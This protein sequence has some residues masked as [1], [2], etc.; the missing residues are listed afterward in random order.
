M[1][2]S[3]RDMDDETPFLFSFKT[4]ETL[5]GLVAATLTSPLMLRLFKETTS[6]APCQ[7]IFP[8]TNV[9]ILI[10]SFLVIF[11]AIIGTT[12]FVTKERRHLGPLGDITHVGHLS[13]LLPGV[14]LLLIS[15]DTIG[16]AL[17]GIIILL[18]II[19]YG[20]RRQ[21]LG[22]H[23]LLVS[24]HTIIGVMVLFLLMGI[25]LFNVMWCLL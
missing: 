7:G 12:R 9:L 4:K 3:P 1:I 20:T 11:W 14:V 21:S 10:L 13:F 5:I 18:V 22:T 17:V 25:V 24:G 16:F 23:I 19:A 2:A 6:V 15:A 8:G